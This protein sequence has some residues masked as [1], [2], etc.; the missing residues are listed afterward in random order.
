VR[1]EVVG[2]AREERVGGDAASRVGRDLAVEV[3]AGASIETGGDH[4]E[5]VGGKAELAMGGALEWLAHAATLEADELT[6][7][8]GGKRVLEMKRS[9]EIAI[10]GANVAIDSD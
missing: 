4:V 10:A 3:K 7:V 9:G 2:A 8:V 6:I 1:V 5:D